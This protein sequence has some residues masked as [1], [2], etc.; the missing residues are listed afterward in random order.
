MPVRSRNRSRRHLSLQARCTQ[1]HFFLLFMN[2]DS[3][4]HHQ[5]HAFRFSTHTAVLEQAT[6]VRNLVQDRNTCH[7]ATF[8]QAFDSAEQN[9][10]AIRNTHSGLDRDRFEDRLLNGQCTAA[11][12]CL[13]LLTLLLATADCTTAAA[14]EAAAAEA[15]TACHGAS[16]SAW[17]R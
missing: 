5:H 3:R 8:P 16:W 4:C 13:A 6:D 11:N 14:T 2:D 15:T 9:C 7:V 12:T 17:R 1:D 10:P